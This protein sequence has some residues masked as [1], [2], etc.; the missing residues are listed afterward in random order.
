[1]LGPVRLFRRQLLADRGAAAVFVGIV[2]VAVAIA[3]A[4]SRRLRLGTVL[5][6]GEEL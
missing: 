6:V 2:G 5:R 3:V 4:S 1:V